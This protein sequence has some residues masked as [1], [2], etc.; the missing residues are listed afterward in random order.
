MRHYLGID[1][2]TFE[3]KGVP[4]DREDAKELYPRTKDLMARLS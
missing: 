4:V 1:I 3:S 2:G